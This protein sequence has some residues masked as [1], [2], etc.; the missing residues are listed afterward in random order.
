MLMYFMLKLGK[1]N[2]RLTNLI[3]LMPVFWMSVRRMAHPVSALFVYL[4]IYLFIYFS[5]YFFVTLLH[6]PEHVKHPVQ[7]GKFFLRISTL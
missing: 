4:F 5:L 1:H 2:H 6:D 7:N 3:K